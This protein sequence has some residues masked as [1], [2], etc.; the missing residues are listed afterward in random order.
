M[1]V[2][3]SYPPVIS[4]KGIPLLTQNRQFQWFNNPTYIYPM[5]PAYAATLLKENGY[6]VLWDDGIAEELDPCQYMDRIVTARPD[7]IVMETK[8]PLIK[9]HWKI[10]DDIKKRLPL[11]KLVLVGDH[12]T[13]FPQESLENCLADY[14]ITGG[15][16]DFLLVNLCNHLSKGETLGPGIWYKKNKRVQNTGQ[17]KHNH[18]LNS[19]PFIDR[20]LTRWQLYARKNGNF[21]KLPGTY[22]MVGRD[23]WWHRC[24]FCSWTTIYP[25]F[26]VRTPQSLLDEIGMLIDNYKVRE[27]FDDTGT[28]PIGK[29]L[30]S[31][32]H[33][34]I[35][36]GYNREVDLGCNMRFGALN[37]KQYSLMRKAGFRY[38]L[39]GLESARQETLDRICKGIKVSDI[40]EGCKMAKAAGLEPHLTIMVGYPWETKEDACRTVE[41]AKY[42]FSR[43]YADTLQATIVIPYPG[44]PLFRECRENDLLIVHDWDDYDMKKSVMKTSLGEDEL[45]KISRDLYRIFFTPKYIIRRLAAIRSLNDLKFI[46]R[47]LKAILGH[48]RD[49]ATRSSSYKYRSSSRIQ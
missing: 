22:T 40:I 46:Q 24:T 48:R 44:T 26:R 21:K 38:L 27:I 36:H 32:C 33:G 49:F 7:V 30:E 11:T 35:E 43:G 34:M 14:I 2:S 28:F 13:A 12:V 25:G 31:F 17:F 19:L 47:G 23:C 10:I 5:I 29:W 41:L 37:Q 42:L 16:Y 3:I 1:K 39:F 4:E 18:D 15:D 45:K 8:T 6:E 9:Y 20:E